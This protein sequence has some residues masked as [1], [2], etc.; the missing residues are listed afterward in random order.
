MKKFNAR[1]KKKKKVIGVVTFLFLF[2]FMYSFIFSY[3]SSNKTKRNL[4]KE[5][6]KY[7][8]NH[9]IFSYVTDFIKIDVNL[10]T[11]LLS[12]NIKMAG[13]SK[14]TNNDLKQTAVIKEKISVPLIYLYN[15]HQSEAYNG[16][17]VYDATKLLSEKL[18][19]SSLENVFEENSI[20]TF[21]QQNSLKY[22]K[23]YEVSKKYL[24]AAKESNPSL[25]YY[26][27]IHRD[28]AL[29]N[30]TTTYYNNKSYA[31]VLFIVGKA[32]PTYLQ[33]QEVAVKLNELLKSR[34]PTISRGIIQKEGK[35]VNG[36]YNQDFSPNCILIELGGLENTKEEVLNTINVIHDAFSVFIRGSL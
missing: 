29:H 8:N 24:S 27:D 35:G 33:N 10:P 23:S 21:L 25:E 32:N 13:N 17:S 18:S 15:T 2:L 1:K 30:K 3:L 5:N 7:V 9:S 31:K 6:K 19:E 4:L 34:V 26:V 12:S 20:T 36:V 14:I 11:T 16:Y 22:Y 28:S